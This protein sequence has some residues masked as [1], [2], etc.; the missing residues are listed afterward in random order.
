L[1]ASKS[2]GLLAEHFNNRNKR[3]SPQQKL[4]QDKA[5]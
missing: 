5:Y 3:M 1:V 2:L 4:N